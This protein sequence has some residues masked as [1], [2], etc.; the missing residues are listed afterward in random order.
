[1]MKTE[2][3]NNFFSKKRNFHGNM[4]NEKR[5]MMEEKEDLQICLN[6][7]YICY[8]YYSSIYNRIIYSSNDNYRIISG[9]HF[10]NHLAI[11]HFI[12]YYHL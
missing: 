6:G 7:L 2:K 10:I 9:L 12:L 4:N 3:W 5:K 8:T 1:M 11:I